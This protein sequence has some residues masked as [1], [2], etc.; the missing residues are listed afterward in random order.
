M[1]GVEAVRDNGVSLL[2]GANEA[3][4]DGSPGRGVEHDPQGLSRPWLIEAYGQLWIVAQHRPD[5]DDV[6]AR[7]DDNSAGQRVA[8]PVIQR[9]APCRSAIL[10]SRVIPP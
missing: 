6:A 2:A 5:A 1:L 8:S 9:E 7:R 10:P 4:P 3:R